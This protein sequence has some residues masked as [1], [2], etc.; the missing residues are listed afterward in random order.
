MR[1]ETNENPLPTEGGVEPELDEALTEENQTR[2]RVLVEHANAIKT[3]V[4]DRYQTQDVYVESG[5]PDDGASFV[6]TDSTGKVFHL[7]V[8][9]QETNLVPL[10][11][12]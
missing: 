2:L 4:Q 5:H 1:T 8:G 6:F 9:F 7:H 3:L 11:D 10:D 12:E